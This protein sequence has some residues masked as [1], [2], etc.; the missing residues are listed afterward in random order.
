MA[1]LTDLDITRL[2]ARAMGHTWTEFDEILSIPG[3]GTHRFQ[4]STTGYWTIRY[5]PLTD[6][7][8][9]MALVKRFRLNCIHGPQG[10]DG[11]ETWLATDG[12]TLADHD[13][14]NRAICLCVARMQLENGDG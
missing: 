2:C 7:A 8:Q 6:D 13:D 9:C 14:L 3:V 11:P 5:D 4:N 12:I 10:R 1:D